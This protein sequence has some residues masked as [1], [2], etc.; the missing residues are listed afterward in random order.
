MFWHNSPSSACQRWTGV[1]GAQR[2]ANG[3]GWCGLTWAQTGILG[4]AVPRIDLSTGGRVLARRRMGSV[5]SAMVRAE[6]SG[7][8]RRVRRARS[9]PS[10][11]PPQRNTKPGKLVGWSLAAICPVEAAVGGRCWPRTK[12]SAL[13]LSTSYSCVVLGTKRLLP[14]A[15]RPVSSPRK[16]AKRRAQIS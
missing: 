1:C 16:R 12:H 8:G 13:F 11:P 10:S 6:T 4:P 9:S 15:R 2:K 14:L 5:G 3:G 7:L